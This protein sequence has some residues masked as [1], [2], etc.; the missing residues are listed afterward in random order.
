LTDHEPK[1]I[2]DLRN[3]ETGN[4]LTNSQYGEAWAITEIMRDTIQKTGRFADKLTDYTFA[5]SR[6]ERFGQIKGETIVRDLFKERFGQTMNQMREELMERESNLPDNAHELALDQAKRVEP[7]IRDGDTMP[8]YRAYDH[9]A[10]T[11][12]EHFYITE[13]AAKSLMKDAFREAEGSELY[14]AGK[15]WEKEFHMPKRE[16]AGQVRETAREQGPVRSM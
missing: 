8:F 7:M 1:K 16:N 13:N 14:D 3:G 15:A 11:V 9:A 6:T 10:H 4:T 5:L 12:S 2:Y